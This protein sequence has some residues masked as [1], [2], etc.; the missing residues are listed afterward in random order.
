MNLQTRFDSEVAEDKI[1]AKVL[2]D[3][4]PLQAI[5]VPEA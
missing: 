5:H 4:Q 2:R 1:A 3:V